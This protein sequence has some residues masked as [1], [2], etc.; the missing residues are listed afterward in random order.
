MKVHRV[1]II[2]RSMGKSV[3]CQWMNFSLRFIETFFFFFLY[4]IFFEVAIRKIY[5]F[6]E[7]ENEIYGSRERTVK[8][9]VT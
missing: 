5:Y 4:T 9:S 2:A 8:G 7:H 1:G 3:C 6:G